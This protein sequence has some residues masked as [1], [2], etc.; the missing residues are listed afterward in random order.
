MRRTS[1]LIVLA[2]AAASCGDGGVSD[3]S[4]TTT[5]ATVATTTTTTTTAQSTT[6]TVGPSDTTPPI[7]TVWGSL[8]VYSVHGVVSLSGTLDEPGRVS[9]PGAAIS[10]QTGF[11]WTADFERES[12]VHQVVVTA[13]D[14]AGNGSE[15]VVQL[16]VDPNLEV[17]FAYVTEFDGSMVTTDY[18]TFLT[19]DEATAA[20]REDGV[21]GAD[22]TVPNDFYIRNDNP[23]LR[24]LPVSEQAPVVLQT[25]FLDGPCVRQT[26]VTLE[27]WSGLLAEQSAGGLPDGWQWY[28]GGA[29]PYWLTLQDGVVVHV[30]EQYLP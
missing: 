2:L 24:E 4:S 11:D 23:T 18:A 10:E 21:I 29:L 5:S 9:I 19:G 6:T 30:A 3:T 25:C 26:A 7:I 14:R 12:G 8:D 16:T 27:Q 15:V 1:A 17:V 28:G 13:E 20:A 22:E